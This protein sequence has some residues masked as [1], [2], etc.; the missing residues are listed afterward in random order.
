MIS[1]VFYRNIVIGIVGEVLAYLF[2]PLIC[3]MNSCNYRCL[4]CFWII[5]Q[6]N[7]PNQLSWGIRQS[8]YLDLKLFSG[9]LCWL[10]QAWDF[11]LTFSC[12]FPDYTWTISHPR[13][14]KWP[15]ITFQVWALLCVENFGM[16]FEWLLPL[17]MK[18]Y[19]A[20]VNYQIVIQMSRK[21][22]AVFVQ[23]LI[24]TGR[25][26]KSKPLDLIVCAIY[27]LGDPAN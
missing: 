25:D 13:G 22:N 11:I 20:M 19:K 7:L 26:R 21:Q 18:G 1:E 9:C 8:S 15:I 16:N 2:H 17:P 10:N 12:P 14:P 3:I 6:N 27:S 24:N 4:N 5:T 23:F